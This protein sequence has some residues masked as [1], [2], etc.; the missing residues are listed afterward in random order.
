MI[1]TVVGSFVV[2]SVDSLDGSLD[3]S[4]TGISSAVVIG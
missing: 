1:S 3:A 4:V 2:S